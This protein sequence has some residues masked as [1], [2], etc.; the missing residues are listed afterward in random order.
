VGIELD[1]VDAL[2]VAAV[3]NLGV[4]IPSSPG[5]VG[6]YQWLG[7]ASLGLLGVADDEALAFAILLHASWY[8]PTTLL[9]GL[10]L[11]VRAVRARSAPRPSGDAAADERPQ[12]AE[13]V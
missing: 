9:G 2:F 6:T 12:D 8:L 13:P 7:V 4:A 5:F 11:A 10:A 3:M 1:L